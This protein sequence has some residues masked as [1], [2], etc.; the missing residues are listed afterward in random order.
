[1][2][3][4][5]DHIYIKVSWKN[6]DIPCP[7]CESYKAEQKYRNIAKKIMKILKK[8]RHRTEFALFGITDTEINKLE[9]ELKSL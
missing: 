6:K 9:K 2:P 7:L 8:I 3:E 4:C 1:M 5:T